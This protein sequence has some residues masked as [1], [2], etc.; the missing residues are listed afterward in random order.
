MRLGEILV[1]AGLLDDTRLQAALAEQKKWG[2][3]LGR[4]LVDMGFVDEHTLVA[5]LSRNL[6]LAAV[7]LE[8]TPPPADV[9]QHLAVQYCER[10]GIFPLGTDSKGRVLKLATTDPTNYELLHTLELKIGVRIEPV[11]AGAK[12]IDRAIRRYYYGESPATK[13]AL[14]ADFGLHEANYTAALQ[15]SPAKPPVPPVAAALPAPDLPRSPPTD[16]ELLERVGRLEDLVS[17]Q[18]RALRALVEMLVDA[19]QLDRANYV[20]RVRGDEPP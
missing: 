14:P 11:V 15:P 18:A 17:R 12:D 13:T 9:V 4:I 20:K 19:G 1:R 3:R 6:D 7:D 5:A 8:A 16:A 2:G 10:Y